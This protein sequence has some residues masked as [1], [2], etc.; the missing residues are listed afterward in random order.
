[1][2][3]WTSEILWCVPLTAVTAVTIAFHVGGI[4]GI[5][6]LLAQAKTR[7]ERRQSGPLAMILFAVAIF[8]LAGWALSLLH[9]VETGMWAG[10]Y[11]WPGAIDTLADAIL[12]SLDSLT[13]RGASGI[14]Q[15]PPWRLMGAVEAA[16]G[17]LLFGISTGFLAAA[18]GNFWHRFRT[19]A[20]RPSHAPPRMRERGPHRHGAS[21]FRS[22]GF[23]KLS[24]AARAA[25]PGARMAG[26]VSFVA[27]GRL[28]HCRLALMTGVESRVA[29]GC[30]TL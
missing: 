25:R 8:G 20:P 17:V 28:R 14:E 2:T 16:N 5:G 4:V 12:Y 24:C 23:L 1:M 18:V 21:R 9:F 26:P 29:S 27:G 22:H 10:A 11:L 3:V 6:V 30:R 15:G 13:T 7:G 19:M